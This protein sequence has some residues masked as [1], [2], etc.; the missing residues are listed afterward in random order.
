MRERE[1]EGGDNLNH[2]AR[3]Y[4]ACST[5]RQAEGGMN[6]WQQHNPTDRRGASASLEDLHGCC[7][8]MRKRHLHIGRASLRM[9]MPVDTSRRRWQTSTTEMPSWSA[10]H[11]GGP[12]QRK[13][14]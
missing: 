8:Q 2:R 4:T 14:G 3:L 11:L 10:M 5:H 12:L 9:G 13:E 6:G 7:V 1:E